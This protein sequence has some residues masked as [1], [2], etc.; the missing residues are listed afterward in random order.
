M[1]QKEVHVSTEQRI[2]IKFLVRD[3]MKPIEIIFVWHWRSPESSIHLIATNILDRLLA[4]FRQNTPLRTRLFAWHNE[5]SGAREE[6]EIL[7]HDR[8]PRTSVYTENI[9]AV[10]RLVEQNRWIFLFEIVEEVNISYGSVQKITADDL[11]LQ[12]GSAKWMPPFCIGWKFLSSCW[13]NSSNRE[14][15]LAKKEDKF[16]QKCKSSSW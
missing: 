9:E 5:F 13:D 15:C 1:S 16:H 11:E 12:K 8:R 6:V 10:R 3:G 14:M 7:S 4:Q 2:I